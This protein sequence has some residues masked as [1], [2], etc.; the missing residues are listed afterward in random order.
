MVRNSLMRL[1]FTKV[2][3]PNGT[4]CFSLHIKAM[5]SCGTVNCSTRQLLERARNYTLSVNLTA[6]EEKELFGK[7]LS[8]ICDSSPGCCRA[9]RDRALESHDRDRADHLARQRR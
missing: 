8:R 2:R 3:A 1:Q 9:R 4:G 7:L 5:L 6:R